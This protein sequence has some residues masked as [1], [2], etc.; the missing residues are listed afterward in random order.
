MERQI[1]YAEF[2]PGPYWLHIS[3]ERVNLPRLMFRV[4]RHVGDGFQ[5]EVE[6]VVEEELTSSLTDAEAIQF[7]ATY[8]IR[9][10]TDL[11]NGSLTS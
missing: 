1:F 6:N 11:L 2:D 7:V 5:S 10:A 3:R 4:Q 9:H 8:I